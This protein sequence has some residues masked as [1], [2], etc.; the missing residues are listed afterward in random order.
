MDR[1]AQVA[2]QEDIQDGV[3]GCLGG[4]PGVGISVWITGQSVY[5]PSAQLNTIDHPG[6]RDILNVHVEVMGPSWQLNWP[7]G[8]CIREASFKQ[9][10]GCDSTWGLGECF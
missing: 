10:E 6:L 3:H 8:I 1:R 4:H 2:D 7:C 9:K 5:A